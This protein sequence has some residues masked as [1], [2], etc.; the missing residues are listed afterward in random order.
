MRPR[1]DLV[2]GEAR[3]RT[4][5]EMPFNIHM[6]MLGS[7]WKYGAGVQKR[8]QGWRCKLGVTST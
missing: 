3:S 6:E 7:S 4:G 1:G 5:F 8:G 2:G